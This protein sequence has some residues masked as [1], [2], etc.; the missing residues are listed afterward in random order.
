M[1]T[2]KRRRIDVPYN[3]FNPNLQ[4]QNY[5]I[6]DIYTPGLVAAAQAEWGKDV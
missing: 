4:K 2:A 1:A 6:G 5:E 3:F